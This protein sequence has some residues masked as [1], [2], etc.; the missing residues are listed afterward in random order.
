MTYAM[1]A[2]SMV[3]RMCAQNCV[4]SFTDSMNFI[5]AF[6][7]E[8]FCIFDHSQNQ[9]LAHILSWKRFPK[10]KIDQLDQR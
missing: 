1:V 8:Q 2:K 6:L 7:C 3:L 5:V 10:F 4:N 9:T